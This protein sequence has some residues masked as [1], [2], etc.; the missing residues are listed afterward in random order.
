VTTGIQDDKYIEIL[1]GLETDDEVVTDPYSAVSKKLNNNMLIK[2]VD[3]QD[4]FTDNKK[5]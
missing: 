2:V 1:T 4:L 5:K 3:K